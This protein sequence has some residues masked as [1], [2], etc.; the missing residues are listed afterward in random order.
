VLP[1][2]YIQCNQDPQKYIELRYHARSG[3]YSVASVWFLKQPVGIMIC[4]QMT[5]FFYP[6]NE[7]MYPKMVNYLFSLRDN[8]E[9]IFDPDEQSFGIVGDFFS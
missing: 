3:D 2:V 7:V 5:T 6:T 1:D 8:D 4:N 9:F